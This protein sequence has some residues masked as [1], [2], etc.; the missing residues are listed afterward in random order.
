MKNDYTE[1]LSNE[2]FERRSRNSSYSLRA[3]ARD[4]DLPASNLSL[5]LKKK[6]G[7]SGTTAKQVAKKLG[8]SKTEQEIFCQIVEREHSRSKLVRE[9]AA[10]SIEE[11]SQINTSL[12][13]D[14]MRVLGNWHYFAIIE[15]FRTSTFHDQSVAVIAK[16]LMIKDTDVKEAIETLLKLE[17][18][19]IK[20]KKYHAVKDYN[21]SPDGIPSDIIR[22]FHEKM[23]NKSKESL[24]T[25]SVDERDFTSMMLSVDKSD[26][27]EAKKVIR[28]FIKSFTEKFSDKPTSDRIYT[29]NIQLFNL[30]Q[31]LEQG[32][33]NEI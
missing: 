31:G 33:Q 23:L 19:E 27:P 17:L 10:K 1:I 5:I 11:N 6:K 14:A 30:T 15:L 13:M 25:Q 29:L 4:L 7:M 26:L 32:S 18:I 21:W 9:N 28:Q 20:K 22:R 3:F 16:A 12:T 24:F 2:F 8:L